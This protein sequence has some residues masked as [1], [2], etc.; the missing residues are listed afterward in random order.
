MSPDHSEPSQLTSADS[1][2]SVTHPDSTGGKPTGRLRSVILSGFAWSVGTGVVI[3]VTRILFA[4]AL[5]RLLSP[6]EYGVA[7]MALVVSALV[8]ALTDLSLGVGLVQRATIDEA[9]RSTVFWTNTGVGAVLSLVGFAVAGPVAAFYGEPAV[10]GLFQVLSSTFLIGALGA[11][12]A[13]LL[14]REMNFR[15]INMRVGVS[16]IAGGAVGVIAAAVGAGAWA[17]IIQQ[18]AV[19]VL[20]TVLLWASLP[21]RPRRV[22]S[23]HSLG[24]LG[25]FGGSVFGARLSD[26]VRQNSERI[27]IGRFLGPAPLGAYSVG[28]NILL[29]PVGRFMVAVMDTLFPALSRLQDDRP[30]M[31]KVWLRLNTMFTAAFAPGLIGLAV[32]APDFVEVLLGTR[33]ADIT[34]VLQ[35]LAVG[36]LAQVVSALG[37][38]VL[39]A[40]G[41]AGT[42]LRFSTVE[43]IF[44]VIATVVGLRWG[45]VGVAAGYAAVSVPTR[46][47][48]VWL[49]SSSVGVSLRQFAASLRGVTEASTAMLIATAGVQIALSGPSIPAEL[50]LAIVVTVGVAVYVPLCLWRVRDIRTELWQMKQQ[51]GG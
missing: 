21:W 12:H 7:N 9:D 11:T 43:A 25:A 34:P 29:S 2:P 30:R 24:Q 5:A 28:F 36:V 10:K 14:H 39:K 47:Y 45:I 37:T 40:T 51:L 32:V 48:F 20:S 19:A 1:R 8:S 46:V 41:R 33:W 27:L 26:Y 50:R 49:T 16:T 18:V 23:K 13:A 22:F 15:A 6:G 31:A 38:E 35:I 44:F 3:Q 17:L 4:V 42:F